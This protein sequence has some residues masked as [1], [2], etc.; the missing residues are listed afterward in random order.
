LTFLQN[1]G[2]NTRSNPEPERFSEQTLAPERR[3]D[4]AVKS[5]RQP[6]QNRYRRRRRRAAP[7]RPALFD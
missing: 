7:D 4:G 2:G 3:L 1:T 6:R 5:G